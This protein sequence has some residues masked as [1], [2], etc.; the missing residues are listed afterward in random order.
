MR[1]GISVIRSWWYKIKVK[2]DGRENRHGLDERSAMRSCDQQRARRS[3]HS[4]SL[5]RTNKKSGEGKGFHEH[6][7]YNVLSHAVM[8]QGPWELMTV[9]DLGLGGGA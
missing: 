5:T 2:H 9:P 4:L 3:T 6:P 8:Q 1:I 7:R